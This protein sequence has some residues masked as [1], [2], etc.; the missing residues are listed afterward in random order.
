MD[1][2]RKALNDKQ[3][4]VFCSYF[5]RLPEEAYIIWH[6]WPPGSKKLQNNNHLQEK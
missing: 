4:D 3:K 6:T 5:H 2:A 1:K